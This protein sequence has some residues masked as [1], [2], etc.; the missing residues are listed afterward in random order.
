ME[1]VIVGV[2]FTAHEPIARMQE[3][4][5]L[6]D[7]I[8]VGVI[9]V[10]GDESTTVAEQIKAMPTVPAG[11]QVT[12]VRVDLKPTVNAIV[13]EL[14]T[15]VESPPKTAVRDCIPTPAVGE[16][17]TVQLADL[18]LVATSVHGGPPKEPGPLLENVMVPTGLEGLIGAMSVTLAVQVV[19]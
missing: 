13:L 3:P 19:G 15:C 2:R 5:G 17:V 16:Y 7:R 12:V 14:P 18:A 9:S 8:P 11:G 1:P 10:P 6:N 4:L